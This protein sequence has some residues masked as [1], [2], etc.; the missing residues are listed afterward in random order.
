MQ[1]YVTERVTRLVEQVIAEMHRA[2]QEVTVEIVH[3]LRVSIRRFQAALRAFSAFFP[4]EES[5]QILKQARKV[6]KL[7][8][9]VRDFDI[10]LELASESGLPADGELSSKLTAL[11]Q[12]AAAKLHGHVR[13]MELAES[14]KAWLKELGL[15][16]NGRSHRMKNKLFTDINWANSGEPQRNARRNLPLLARRF[17]EAGEE[18]V[19]DR[20]TSEMLHNFRL[21][22]KQVRYLLE[23]LQDC[24]PSR[25]QEQIG[26][27]K[28]L[29]DHLGAISDCRAT[30]RILQETGLSELPEASHLKR[31]LDRKA[32]EHTQAFIDHWRKTLGRKEVQTRWVDHL[33]GPK[34]SNV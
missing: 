28:K 29:Q 16:A 24:Y 18:T 4:E 11:R 19:R 23:F 9:R 32:Q 26:E 2:Q 15:I 22:G 20:S 14:G 27:M 33:A 21:I 25:L 1:S 17:I 10:A 12:H 5:R 8:G 13:R 7:A 31:D 3:D 6:L 34:E 30:T